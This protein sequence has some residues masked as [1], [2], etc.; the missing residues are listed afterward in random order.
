MLSIIAGPTANIH[1]LL[2]RV[3][4][5]QQTDRISLPFFTRPPA[6]FVLAQRPSGEQLQMATYFQALKSAAYNKLGRFDCAEELV[7]AC[8]RTF[9]VSMSS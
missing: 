1:P 7:N 3:L 6:E 8:P 4:I 2:H 9:T 5:P